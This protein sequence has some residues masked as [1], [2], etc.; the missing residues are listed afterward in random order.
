MRM[1]DQVTTAP[2]PAPPT[3][4]FV[5]PAIG[6]LAGIGIALLVI[7]IGTVVA[8]LFTLRGADALTK[9]FPAGYVWGKLVAAVIGAFAG[10]FTTSRITTGR[11]MYTVGLLSLV[12][13]A[14]A[15]GPALRGTSAFPNDPSWFP[16]TLAIVELIAVMLGGVFER[17]LERGHAA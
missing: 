16:L 11:S 3:S 17:W 1:P 9:A 14:A 4:T 8:G 12:L 7:A 5:R 15:G 2:P 6:L 13:F 10:G